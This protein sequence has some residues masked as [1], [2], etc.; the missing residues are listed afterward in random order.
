[1]L[2]FIVQTDS[3]FGDVLGIE[4]WGCAPPDGKTLDE[5]RRQKTVQAKSAEQ[6]RKVSFF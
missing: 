1:L 3:N 6:R 5:Q 2:L 4:V